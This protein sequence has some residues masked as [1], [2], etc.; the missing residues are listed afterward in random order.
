MSNYK[1][2]FGRGV[3]SGI[4]WLSENAAPLLDALSNTLQ[5]SIESII[6]ALILCPPPLFIAASAIGAFALRR[7]YGLSL[8]VAIAFLAT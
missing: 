3:E 6:F 1:L 2:P 5:I 7:S 8:F 4:E